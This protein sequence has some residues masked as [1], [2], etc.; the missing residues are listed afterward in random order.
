MTQGTARI[1]KPKGPAPEPDLRSEA[2]Y[3]TRSNLEVYVEGIQECIEAE[4]RVSL[5]Y[6]AT[7]KRFSFGMAK[8]RHWLRGAVP[9]RDNLVGFPGGFTGAEA[10]P[11]TTPKAAACPHCGGAL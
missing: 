7:G 9:R 2:V 5:Q 11:G 10:I 8:A 3:M 6:L 4:P 1:P